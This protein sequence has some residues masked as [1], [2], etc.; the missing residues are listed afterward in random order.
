[1][2][3][4][5]FLG[6]FEFSRHRW[7]TYKRCKLKQGGQV[8]N[9]VFFNVSFFYGKEVS[10][11]RLGLTEKISAR[12]PRTQNCHI[13]SM[14]KDINKQSKNNRFSLFPMSN[15][16]EFILHIFWEL[17]QFFPLFVVFQISGTTVGVS[18]LKSLKR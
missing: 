5:N 17:F 8:F 9:F 11:V 7:K 4:K 1:M 15:Y 16:T 3:K 10:F 18:M 12:T 13:Y 2:V 14:S 6:Y